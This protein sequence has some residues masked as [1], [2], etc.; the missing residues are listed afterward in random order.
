M[1]PGWR[2]RWPREAQEASKNDQKLKQF[3]QR[4]FG[5][6]TNSFLPILEVLLGLCW[7]DLGN[8]NR[9]K[10]AL[11]IQTIFDTIFE[12]FWLR[13]GADLGPGYG[14][15]RDSLYERQKNIGKHN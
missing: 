15:A 14:V 6:E 7:H 8:Q 2:K 3:L 4:A 9:K 5:R 11:K 13:F 10:I 12:A 1:N